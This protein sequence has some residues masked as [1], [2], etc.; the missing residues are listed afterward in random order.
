MGAHQCLRA[1]L[2]HSAPHRTLVA[3]VQRLI[4]LLLLP[5]PLP[6]L[7]VV[8]RAAWPTRELVVVDRRRDVSLDDGRPA[9]APT[10]LLH[11]VW[12]EQP[13][14]PRPE[15]QHRPRP[16]ARRGR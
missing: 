1:V 10:Q 5:R 6:I 16:R 3:H 12:P 8:L 14:R 9:A 15:H 11:H 7:A 4:P 13:V 2:G